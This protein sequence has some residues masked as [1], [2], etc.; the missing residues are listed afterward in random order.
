MS[1]KDISKA[2][3]LKQVRAKIKELNCNCY[4]FLAGDDHDSEY[5][6]EAD[7]RTRFLTGFTGS[8]G[9]AIVCE[10]EAFF[11][12]RFKIFSTS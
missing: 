5:P 2:D 3:I 12:D 6:P 8:A 11:F 1:E 9:T 7:K 4:I 10:D